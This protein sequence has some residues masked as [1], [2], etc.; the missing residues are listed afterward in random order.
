M[1]KINGVQ[2]PTPSTYQIGIYDLSRA[3]RNAAG[4]IVID[5]IATKRKIEL[6]WRYLTREQLSKLLTLV[7]PVF[8]EVE[9]TDPQSNEIEKGIFYCGDRLVQAFDYKNGRIRYKDI[10]FNIIER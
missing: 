9:Y 2:I 7:S 1:I 4:T 10:R 6:T 8:F 3:E 5:R